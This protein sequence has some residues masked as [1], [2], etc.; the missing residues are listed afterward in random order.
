MTTRQSKHNAKKRSEQKAKGMVELREWT[1]PEHK[2]RLKRLIKRL[3]KQ[4]ENKDG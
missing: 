3:N 2:G 4:R 1:Y